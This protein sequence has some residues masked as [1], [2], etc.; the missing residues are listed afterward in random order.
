MDL[1]PS[2][3]TFMRAFFYSFSFANSSFLLFGEFPP[4]AS[5]IKGD[6]SLGY[7]SKDI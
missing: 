1:V 5:T 6:P 2:L 4:L 7:Y 3:K